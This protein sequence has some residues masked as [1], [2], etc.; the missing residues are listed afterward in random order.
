MNF[1]KVAKEIIKK[2]LNG[3]QNL[4]QIATFK[5]KGMGYYYSVVQSKL[6][7]VYKQSEFFLLPLNKDDKGRLFILSMGFFGTG[8][9]ILVPAEEIEILEYN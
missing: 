5:R 8:E 1:P 7:H 6:I 3:E 9:I 2:V 4:L